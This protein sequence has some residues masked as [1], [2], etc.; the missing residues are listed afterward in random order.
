MDVS[1]LFHEPSMTADDKNKN[2]KPFPNM[3]YKVI[4]IVSLSFGF[5]SFLKT[6]RDWRIFNFY[7]Y[8]FFFENVF[9]SHVDITVL[10]DDGD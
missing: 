6:L 2:T 8:D 7:Y 1:K 10:L 4:L 5:I 3:V 9:F